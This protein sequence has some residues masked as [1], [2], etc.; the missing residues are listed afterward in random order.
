MGTHNS[1]S[2]TR[3]LNTVYDFRIGCDPRLQDDTFKIQSGSSPTMILEWG[4]TPPPRGCLKI[5]SGSSPTML[6]EWGVTSA[7]T[8]CLR[9]TKWFISHYDFRMGCHPS[10]QDDTLKIQSGSSPSMMV[11]CLLGKR[12]HVFVGA[13]QQ[14]QCRGNRGPHPHLLHFRGT[15]CDLSG[16][17]PGVFRGRGPLYGV[18]KLTLPS[19][20]N[21]HNKRRTSARGKEGLE[22]EK[23]SHC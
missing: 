22:R 23:I 15:L 18:P 16:R 5:Q 8:W 21:F 17:R 19:T 11:S 9:N 1:W 3:H 4:V 6:S 2:W 10:L 7:P 12:K 14:D 20:V 13:L